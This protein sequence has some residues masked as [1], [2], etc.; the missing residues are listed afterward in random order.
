MDGAALRAEAPEEVVVL[1][2]VVDGPL[3]LGARA[4][5]AHAERRATA[6][7]VRDHVVL[8]IAGIAA[9]A[10][11]RDGRHLGPGRTRALRAAAA[12]AEEPV[13]RAVPPVLAALRI[14]D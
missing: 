10:D 2:R 12:R 11:P 7:V 8:A 6:V 3:A 5:A 1:G 9:R 4:A 13:D 14:P